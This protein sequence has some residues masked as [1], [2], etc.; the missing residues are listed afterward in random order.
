MAYSRSQ[1]LPCHLFSNDSRRPYKRT[2]LPTQAKLQDR[3]DATYTWS[4][5]S[6]ATRNVSAVV[7]THLALHN[8][9]MAHRHVI[10][11]NEHHAECTR[12]A[13]PPFRNSSRTRK[14][15][16]LWCRAQRESTTPSP[17][18]VWMRYYLFWKS[19]LW[20]LTVAHSHRRSAKGGPVWAYYLAERVKIRLRN[21]C[22]R[23]SAVWL[24][25]LLENVR[26][27]HLLLL[28]LL[29]WIISLLFSCLSTHES[30]ARVI[31]LRPARSILWSP[32]SGVAMHAQLCLDSF[33][34]YCAYAYMTVNP[35]YGPP[36]SLPFYHDDNG[37]SHHTRNSSRRHRH[38]R[39]YP[40]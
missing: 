1:R 5:I 3:L 12:P 39:V 35:E 32:C 34:L 2:T 14:E 29:F 7:F 20:S 26:M 21:E 8:Y 33:E 24:V 15:R 28:F 25:R 30:G 17:Q 27:T 31:Y 10:L 37:P 6:A 40:T 38:R 36:L 16:V 4:D 19:G 13:K 18:N 23:W 9:S 11:V 22:G